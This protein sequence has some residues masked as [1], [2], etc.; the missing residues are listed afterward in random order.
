MKKIIFIGNINNALNKEVLTTLNKEYNVQL[1]NGKPVIF[2]K[3]CEI[4]KPEFVFI[5]LVAQNEAVDE[6]IYHISNNY[7]S[8]AV[9]TLGS[10]S[11]MKPYADLYNKQQFENILRPVSA[12]AIY[13]ECRQ[14]MVRAQFLKTSVADDENNLDEESGPSKS[15]K[16]KIMICDDNQLMLR[17]L[18]EMLSKRYEII[19]AASGSQALNLLEKKT[20][21]LILLDYE[22]P[23]MNGRQVYEILRG[24]P[25]YKDIP[26][27]FLTGISTNEK[28]IEVLK[29]KP[30]GYILKPPEADALF[31]KIEEVIGF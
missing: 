12:E 19:M 5:S 11:E 20:I 16:K 24:T 18:K 8:C 15:F 4:S 3:L 26:V 17:N 7:K 23:V 28:V 2:D 29:L 14:T 25:E 6:M 9:I 10:K 27:I 31:E 30:A 21:D 22:M 1:F 13:D